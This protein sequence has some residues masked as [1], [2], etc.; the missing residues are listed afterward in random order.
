MGWLGEDT[1]S[2]HCGWVADQIEEQDMVR[3]CKKCGCV[4]ERR[5][6]GWS[7][8]ESDNCGVTKL[9]RL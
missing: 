2:C 3:E 9:Q 6:W 5:S 8:N 1:V 7:K 4:Y